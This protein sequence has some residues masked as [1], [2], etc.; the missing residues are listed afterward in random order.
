MTHEG[1]CNFEVGKP[2][3]QMHRRVINLRPQGLIYRCTGHKN[4]CQ[5]F[6]LARGTEQKM[7]H[8]PS[9]NKLFARCYV[10][11][12]TQGQKNINVMVTK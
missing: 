3:F 4:N 11:K 10:L 8:M 6:D 7:K 5:L 12:C 1:I 2:L 9:M